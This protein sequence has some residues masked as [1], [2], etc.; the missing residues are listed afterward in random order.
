MSIDMLTSGSARRLYGALS[1]EPA[2]AALLE[3][4][5]VV[6]MLDLK[7]IAAGTPKEKFRCVARRY[8]RRASARA[9]RR[10]DRA[11]SAAH[12]RARALPRPAT[13]AV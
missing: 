6:Q 4:G 7:A 12:A 11:Q 5:V 2:M 10:A 1:D 3:A 9:A 8:A 13:R